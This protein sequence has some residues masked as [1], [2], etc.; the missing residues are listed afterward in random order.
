MKQIKHIIH[1]IAGWVYFKTMSIYSLEKSNASLSEKL[2]ANGVID[3]HTYRKNNVEPFY[4]KDSDFKISVNKQDVIRM[5]G[6]II[7]EE[8]LK[9]EK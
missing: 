1:R 4:V 7:Y 9:N 6:R 5:G 8:G 3:A 2:L